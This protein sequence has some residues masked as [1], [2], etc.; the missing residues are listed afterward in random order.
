[1]PTTSC[2]HCG[3]VIPIELHEMST[4]FECAQC[5]GRFTPAGGAYREKAPEESPPF[6]FSSYE[7]IPPPR[8]NNMGIIAVFGAMIVTIIGLVI[9]IAIVA[10]RANN[11]QAK[12]NSTYRGTPT[13]A[14]ST[15]RP[16]SPRSSS[17]SMSVTEAGGIVAFFTSS[18]CLMSVLIVAYLV[19]LILLMAW[20]ARDCRARGVDGGSVWVFTILFIHW[21]GLIIYLAS[22]P[23]GILVPCSRCGNKRLMA[24]MMCPHCGVKS[25]VS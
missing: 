17:E 22:R 13:P 9:A 24:A 3:R 14:P 16:A 18:V 4:L 11:S 6:E 8:P 1:M 10:N 2:P 7:D 20:V 12:A 21:I 15:P 19:G 5:G 25:E 23:H